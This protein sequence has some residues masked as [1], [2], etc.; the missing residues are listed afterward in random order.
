MNG[1]LEQIASDEVL[2]EAYAWLFDRREHYSH[3]DD[4]W[5]VRFHWPEISRCSRRPCSVGVSPFAAAA[6]PSG[7]RR[8]G[9]WSAPHSL[10]FKAPHPF[11]LSISRKKRALLAND[12]QDRDGKDSNCPSPRPNLRTHTCA[13]RTVFTWRPARLLGRSPRPPSPRGWL[14]SPIES[15]TA[16]SAL[17]PQS[18]LDVRAFERSPRQFVAGPL[19]RRE[20]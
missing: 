11:Y 10:G 15:Q 3:H 17:H 20:R 4:V 2:D 1:L 14:W 8:P 19:T 16:V 6:H 5:D 13:W 12:M 7:Q 9:N 18:P